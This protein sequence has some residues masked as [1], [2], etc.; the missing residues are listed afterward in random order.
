MDAAQ[1]FT[2]FSYVI[3]RRICVIHCYEDFLYGYPTV[4]NPDILS[5]FLDGKESL[6]SFTGKAGDL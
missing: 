2:S 4:A 5:L 6:A 1:G 3:L